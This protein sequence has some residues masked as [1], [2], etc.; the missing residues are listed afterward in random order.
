RKRVRRNDAV[1]LP[2]GEMHERAT[3]RI[4]D[5]VVRLDHDS[6][7][8]RTDNR[9]DRD[10]GHVVTAFVEPTADRR[11]DAEIAHLE[12]RLTLAEW[13]HGRLGRLEARFGDHPDRPLREHHLSI[14]QL[15]MR[16]RRRHEPEVTGTA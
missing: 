6:D 4:L 16:A 15:S 14:R 12:Q 2:A 7:A 5:G 10:T 11:I 1:L 9:S 8:V 3:E 13:R